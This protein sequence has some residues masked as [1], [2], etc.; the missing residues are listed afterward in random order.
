ML[1]KPNAEEFEISMANMRHAP[2]Q[3]LFVPMPGNPASGTW[4]DG[5]AKAKNGGHYDLK[6]VQAMGRKLWAKFLVQQRAETRSGSRSGPA[7]SRGHIS[8]AAAPKKLP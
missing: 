5:H 3:A 7:V 8:V 2:T 4:S 6:E 1:S